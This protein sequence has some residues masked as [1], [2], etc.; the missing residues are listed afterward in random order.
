MPEPVAP[1]RFRDA[2][3]TVAAAVAV[4]STLDERG[5]PRALTISSLCALSLRPPLVSLGIGRASRTHLVF[6][7]APRFAV[8]LLAAGQEDV[9]RRFAG[10]LPGRHEEPLD[11]MDGL[12]VVSGGLTYLLCTTATRLPGGD[13]TII[14]GEVYRTVT[15]DGMPLVYHRREY[16]S[17]RTV[18]ALVPHAS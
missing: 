18:D 9:A 10:Q 13:H 6:A 4:A 1:D 5:R 12:P 3:A 8:T 11:S 16:T 14:I 15:R 7:T 2:L 17:V